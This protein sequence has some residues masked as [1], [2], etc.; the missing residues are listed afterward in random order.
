MDINGA[1]SVWNV[2]AVVIANVTWAYPASPRNRK[3][4]AFSA[5][6]DRGYGFFGFSNAA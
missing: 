3:T 1:Y 4:L 6:I 5:G 2:T